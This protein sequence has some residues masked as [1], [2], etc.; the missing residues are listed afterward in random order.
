MELVL[1]VKTY[2]Y[3]LDLLDFFGDKGCIWYDGNHLYNEDY[4]E[5]AWK[6]YG[7]QGMLL[8]PEGNMVAY[9][10]LDVRFLSGDRKIID[11]DTIEE[12]LYMV[13]ALQEFQLEKEGILWNYKLI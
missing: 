9:A 1:R 7:S 12:L 4:A 3:L 2:D 11:C 5:E 8:L 10:E 6:D 13:K